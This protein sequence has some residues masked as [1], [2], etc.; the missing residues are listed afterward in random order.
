MAAEVAA[1]VAAE[2]AADVAAEVASAG[3][4]GRLR[5]LLLPKAAAAAPAASCRAVWPR[6]EAPLEACHVPLGGPADV[7]A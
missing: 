7:A 4:T 6:E 3:E 1:D 2:V 5:P